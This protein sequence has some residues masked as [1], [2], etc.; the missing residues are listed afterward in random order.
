MEQDLAAVVVR[1]GFGCPSV[2]VVGDRG[3][4]VLGVV[5][6]DC[7]T[8]RLRRSVAAAA[9]DCVSARQPESTSSSACHRSSR[10]S[11]SPLLAALP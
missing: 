9:V 8:V 4:V 5:G 7:C 10:H 6:A 1:W 2:G 11:R 3:P